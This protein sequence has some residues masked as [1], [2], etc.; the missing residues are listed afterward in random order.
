[1]QPVMPPLLIPNI[2][3]VTLAN[4]ISN[5][6]FSTDLS[7][8]IKILNQ[9]ELD[10][11]VANTVASIVKY[12]Y[13][14][15]K[16]ISRLCLQYKENMIT[17]YLNPNMITQINTDEVLQ[18]NDSLYYLLYT[19]GSFLGQSMIAGAHG[20]VSETIWKYPPTYSY[21]ISNFLS[22]LPTANPLLD[23]NFDPKINKFYIKAAS[24]YH[25]NY[26]LQSFNF[27]IST[28]NNWYLQE[29]L[30]QDFINMINIEYQELVQDSNLDARQSLFV[31]AINTNLINKKPMQVALIATTYLENVDNSGL[32]ILPPSPINLYDINGNFIYAGNHAMVLYG[33]ITQSDLIARLQVL[34]INTSIISQVTG[35]LYLKF[36]N[37]WGTSFGDNGFVYVNLMDFLNAYIVNNYNGN[38]F[39]GQVFSPYFYTIDNL[40]RELMNLG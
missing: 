7:A 37:S 2:N 13:N 35:P 1:M 31:Q 23:D 24:L 36:A 29:D 20:M 6:V 18:L 32:L 21:P 4:T 12:N 27:D 16:P 40:T 3:T 17:E 33:I 25:C 10:T 34:N 19:Y 22:P 15:K 9:G 5:I 28:E 26:G 11:C 30:V 8:N 38:S 39:V 14:H